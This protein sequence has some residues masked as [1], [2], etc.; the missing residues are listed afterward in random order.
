MMPVPFVIYADFESFLCKLEGPENMSSSLYFYERHIPS[1]ISCLIISS[2]PSRTYI[3]VV[4]R[5]P[6]VIKEFLK[7]LKTESDNITTILSKLV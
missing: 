7:R 3:P 1:G 5:G 6:D 4:F 2:D